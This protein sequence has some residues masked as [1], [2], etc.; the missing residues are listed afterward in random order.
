MHRQVS[1]QEGDRLW[2][3]WRAT[4]HS[5]I[6]LLGGGVIEA[7][8]DRRVDWNNRTLRGVVD[9]AKAAGY[10]GPPNMAFLRPADVRVAHQLSSEE[11]GEVRVRLSAAMTDQVAALQRLLPI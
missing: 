3:I 1:P 5:T 7:T 4:P 6:Q 8:S 9:A 10:S 2:L 11:L